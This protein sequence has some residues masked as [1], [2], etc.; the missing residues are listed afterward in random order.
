MQTHLCRIEQ[1]ECSTPGRVKVCF[2]DL[3]DNL[4]LHLDLDI[5]NN[6]FHGINE[7]GLI[8]LAIECEQGGV[9]YSELPEVEIAL[10]A[11]DRKKC[12][13]EITSFFLGLGILVVIV[14]IMWLD[15]FLSIS[16]Q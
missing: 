5:N 12:K 16:L 3:E 8:A 15:V 7:N 10:K 6:I 13:L 9:R 1:I 11:E 2:V 4:K 14:G